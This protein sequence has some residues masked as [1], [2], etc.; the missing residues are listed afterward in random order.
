ML[1]TFYQTHLQKQLTQAQ[2]ILLTILLNLIQSEKQVRLE[3]LVR[4]FPYP[5]TTESRR[6][7]LQRF[8]D[9]PQLTLALIW[10][11][12]ITYWLTTYC[13]IGQRLSIAI[14][15][16]QWGCINLF[17]L[18]LIWQKRAIPLYWCLLPKLGNSNLEEQTLAL[19][20]VLPLLKEYKVIVLGDREF[21]SVDLGNWLKTMGV[22]FC[23]RLKKNH[24]LE[25][26]NLIWQRLDQLGIIPGTSLYFQGIRVRKTRPVAGFDIACKWKRNY[27]GIKVKDAWFIL[28]DLGS[29]PVAIAAYKKRMGIEEMFRDYKTG[30]YNIEGT[31]LKGERL[32]KI[33]LLMA[34]AYSSA[35]FQGKEIQ[36]KQL[37]KYISRSKEPR[38]KYRRRSTF[39]I[40]QDG[41]QWVNYLAQHSE[42][43]QELMKLTRNKRRFY[44]QGIRAATL[45]RSSS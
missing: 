7:K 31:G 11:P 35:I 20:Q 36:K 9:L 18:A 1:P 34:I 41:E 43:V 10:F 21:C 30:G 25:T 23:L 38:K 4:V 44:Q 13:P 3:R 40:G 2:F 19:Q 29:L 32:I 17:T 6:R 42:L 28:T 26:E 37:Q 39:G 5:I 15:R 27:Q 45:I 12:L 16:S 24:C 8:L 22:S 33:I 14:D